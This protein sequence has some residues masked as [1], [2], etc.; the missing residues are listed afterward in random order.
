[1]EKVLLADATLKNLQK[2]ELY[3]RLCR[4][5]PLDGGTKEIWLEKNKGGVCLSISSKALAITGIDD[6]R[7][8]SHISTEES[9]YPTVAYLQQTWWLEVDGELEFQFPAWTYNLFFRLKLGKSS[10]RFG[11]WVCNSEHIHGW[12]IK[13]VQFWLTT[14]DGQHAVSRCHLDNPRNWV[15]HH[16]GDF[17]VIDKNKIFNDTD[18]LHSYKRRPLC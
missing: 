1:M 16:V 15:L 18:R 11:R 17:V 14:S 5:N 12:D 13:P 6:R 3:A 8:W 10:K 7:Y 9:R 2:K 4:P